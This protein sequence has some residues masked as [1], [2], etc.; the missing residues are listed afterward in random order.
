MSTTVATVRVSDH[1][2]PAVAETSSFVAVARNEFGYIL[3]NYDAFIWVLGKAT[4]CSVSVS[5]GVGSYT[6]SY[7]PT[8]TRVYSPQ[9]SLYKLS[10]ARGDA[11]STASVSQ[12]EF[13]R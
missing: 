9:L 8:I 12:I 7:V 2:S 13:G 10:L 3:A 11:L 1:P 4:I 6:V 5:R